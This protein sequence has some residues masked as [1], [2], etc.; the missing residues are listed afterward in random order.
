MAE[1]TF[2]LLLE[3]IVQ[4]GF[5]ITGTTR[6]FRAVHIDVCLRKCLLQ[7]HLDILAALFHFILFC[8]TDCAIF[9]NTASG[10]A[11]QIVL[12]LQH[13][14]QFVV[15]PR[16]IMQLHKNG[17]VTAV[18]SRNHLQTCFIAAI[19]AAGSDD[20]NRNRVIR[21]GKSI[22]LINLA[23][24]A[25]GITVAQIRVAV[26]ICTIVF[27]K[28]QRGQFT[29]HLGILDLPLRNLAVDFLFLVG[30]EDIVITKV[31]HQLLLYQLLQSSFHAAF[32][33]VAILVH[34]GCHQRSDILHRR[35]LELLHIFDHEQNLEHFHLKAGFFVIRVQII[36]ALCIGDCN[37]SFM[38][39]QCR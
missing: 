38:V 27:I 1:Q 6:Q 17:V 32:Q 19:I 35:S 8:F 4:A 20:F 24:E 39:N 5:K 36:V 16:I 25:E 10:A 12:N 37:R 11:A 2:H 28:D 31:L 7:E 34:P 9:C 29:V 30:Q 21:T 3:G 22:I 13:G 15:Q 18:T 23:I 33:T 14:T 26:F